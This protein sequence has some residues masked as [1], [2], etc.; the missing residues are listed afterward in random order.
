M[1]QERVE[2]IK[3]DS[4]NATRVNEVELLVLVT[5]EAQTPRTP[6]EG[7]NGEPYHTA[8]SEASPAER[9][10]RVSKPFPPR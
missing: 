2:T 7:Q 8:T 5:P 6:G 4:N 10:L 3:K 1:V 9:S